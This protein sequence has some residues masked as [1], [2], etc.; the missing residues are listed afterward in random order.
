MTVSGEVLEDLGIKPAVI[1]DAV[2]PAVQVKCENAVDMKRKR[3]S[4]TGSE[5]VIDLTGGLEDVKK[6]EGSGK[7]GKAVVFV[8][9]T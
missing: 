8:D 4:V 5:D 3:T 6:E 9:L 1:K 2:I 7:K